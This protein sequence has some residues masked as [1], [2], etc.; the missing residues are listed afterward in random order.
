MEG[1]CQAPTPALLHDYRACCDQHTTAAERRALVLAALL[2]D[3]PLGELVGALA[4]HAA[5]IP[6]CTPLPEGGCDVPQHNKDGHCPKAGKTPRVPWKQYQNG[7]PPTAAEVAKW[8]R[9]WPNANWALVAGPA[10]G[11]LL[12]DEDGPEAAAYLP[13]LVPAVRVQTGRDGGWHHYFQWP[14]GARIKNLVGFRPGWDVRGRGGII[15][16]PGS[17]HPSGKQYTLDRASLAHGFPELP[18]A[19]RVTLETP[20][21][22]ANRCDASTPTAAHGH[23]D[24]ATVLGGV[25]KGR[26]DDTLFRLAG[27]LRR[28]EIPEWAATELV[29]KAAAACRPPY[30]ADQAREKVAR[31]YHEPPEDEHGAWVPRAWLDKEREDHAATRAALRAATDEIAA[32]KRQQPAQLAER[33]ARVTSDWERDRSRRGRLGMWATIWREARERPAADPRLP[34]CLKYRTKQQ[35][36]GENDDRMRAEVQLAEANQVLVRGERERGRRRRGEYKTEQ[37][38]ELVPELRD[39]DLPDFLEAVYR[40]LKAPPKPRK[41]PERKVRVPCACNA[42]ACPNDPTHALVATVARTCDTCGVQVTAPHDHAPALPVRRTVLPA[43]EF[44]RA[45]TANLARRSEAEKLAQIRTRD[46]EAVFLPQMP[47][48]PHAPAPLDRD[49]AT[50]IYDRLTAAIETADV[51]PAVHVA[52]KLGVLDYVRRSVAGVA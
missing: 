16:L 40:K 18:A 48:P 43:V 12:L 45:A 35:G 26:R 3:L 4:G 44:R 47:P 25:D 51:P 20:A 11:L 37:T 14:D 33:T 10:S 17:L 30:P 46:P 52:A 39:L 5:V 6:C 24:P 34:W 27:K 7:P 2:Q 19:L 8:R 29:L 13:E 41:A 32:L 38:I 36:W 23:L 31:V 1:P 21:A 49:H 50:T 28:A 22:T 9:R 15:I 42:D